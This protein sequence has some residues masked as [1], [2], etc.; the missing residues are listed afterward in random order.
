MSEEI[1]R[2]KNIM[3]PEFDKPATIK[4][5][6]EPLEGG[7]YKLVKM[8]CKLEMEVSFRGTQC[9]HTCEKQIKAEN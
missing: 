7:G 2:T 5:T 8:A 3:C 1:E 4:L 9:Y 6:Y